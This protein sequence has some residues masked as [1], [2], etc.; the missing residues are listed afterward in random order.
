MLA[1]I[2]VS[3]MSTG[4]DDCPPVPVTAGASTVT[5][6]GLAMAREGDPLA[7]H[8]CEDHPTHTGTIAGGMDRI[9]ICGR[10]AAYAGVPVSCGGTMTGGSSKVFFRQLDEDAHNDKYYERIRNRLLATENLTATEKTILC[11]PKIAEAEAARC[12]EEKDRIGWN[13]LARM[14]K[15]WLAGPANDNAESNPYP[16]FVE[17]NW[18]LSFTRARNELQTL[19]NTMFNEK[20]R[21][22][23]STVLR[24][25]ESLT[26][27]P[28]TFNYCDVA[29]SLYKPY[30]HQRSDVRY[31]AS[32]DGLAVSLGRFNFWGL[33]SGTIDSV[34]QSELSITVTRCVA[35]VAD[36]FDFAGDQELGMWDCAEKA[37]VDAFGVVLDN[38]EFRSFREKFG[39]GSDFAVYSDPVE[40]TGYAGA[41]F[42]LPY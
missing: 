18:V 8:G 4:H 31:A 25:N 26:S 17:M 6:D 40:I 5:A 10:R 19:R 16:F 9:F 23:L 14:M 21:H 32:V 28:A 15:K 33:V 35:V 12:E 37:Y 24:L 42:F 27:L 13:N 22:D 39:I 7:P 36:R 3:D 20:A 30:Y 11:L 41:Q 34:S 29:P 38:A 1:A 2:R